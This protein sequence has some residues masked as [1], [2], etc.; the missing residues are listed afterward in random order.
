MTITSW[1]TLGHGAKVDG[2]P[3]INTLG[4]SHAQARGTV[5]SHG[6][7]ELRD[8]AQREGASGYLRKTVRGY[9]T[10]TAKS[11]TL[12]TIW[13][14][15]PVTK[16]AG[17]R[18]LLRAGRILCEKFPARKNENLWCICVERLQLFGLGEKVS[19]KIPK[20]LDKKIAF[21]Y[22]VLVRNANALPYIRSL[23]SGRA[24]PP[25]AQ[26][27][28]ALLLSGKLHGGKCRR[29]VYTSYITG[30]LY[31]KSF[32][33]GV[34]ARVRLCASRRGSWGANM[35]EGVR[36]VSRLKGN[37][38][39]EAMKDIIK[40]SVVPGAAV[41]GFGFAAAAYGGPIV[42]AAFWGAVLFAVSRA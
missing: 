26:L 36:R 34:R 38:R 8:M 21:R 9:E 3:C 24:C 27:I 23:L 31:G 2:R 19:K 20:N 4:A 32:P 15:F 16:N 30:C 5:I 40:S 1:T 17:N 25:A 29:I 18:P 10:F 42:W 28:W 11:D 14:Q 7:P 33:M 41:A 13:G 12:Y 22:T 39:R 35:N 37:A 6:P